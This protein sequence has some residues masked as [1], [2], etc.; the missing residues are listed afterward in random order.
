M[1]YHK[2]FIALLLL[3]LVAIV[4]IGG[5]TYVYVQDKSV[6]QPTNVI[7]NAR[8]TSPAQAPVEDTITQSIPPL[9]CSLKST[10]FIRAYSGIFNWY[11]GTTTLSWS[12]NAEYALDPNGEKIPPNGEVSITG[13]TIKK[14]ARFADPKVNGPYKSTVTLTFYNNS[15][16]TACTSP[17]RILPVFVD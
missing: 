15:T 5:G 8:T 13:S 16:S 2:G 9:S 1:N 7:E 17:I 10:G 3:V 12:S 11:S 4:L 6:T 14:Y